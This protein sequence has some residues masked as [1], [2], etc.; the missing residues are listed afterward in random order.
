[1]DLLLKCQLK[2]ELFSKNVL[3]GKKREK[4]GQ[5]IALELKKRGNSM[6]CWGMTSYNHK[7]P[8]HVWISETKEEGM[9]VEAKIACLNAEFE[10]QEKDLNDNWIGSLA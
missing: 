2:L 10:A 8:F 5:V 6:M 9:A 1:M 3:Y 4:N 7:E